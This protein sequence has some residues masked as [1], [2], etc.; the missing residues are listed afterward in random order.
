MAVWI[1]TSQKKKK[2]LRKE[3]TRYAIPALAAINIHHQ[4]NTC[5]SRF[6]KSDGFKKGTMHKH[7]R[8]PIKDLWF[9]P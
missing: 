9:S 1:H 2:K 3:K 7:R 6:S 4:D 5:N 8:R